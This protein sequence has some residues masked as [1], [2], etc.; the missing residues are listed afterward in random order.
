MR[1][2]LEADLGQAAR[3]LLAQGLIVAALHDAEQRAAGQRH[4]RRRACSARPNAASSFMARSISALLGRQPHAFVELHGD[5]GTE[6]NLHFNGALGRQLHHGAVEMRTERHALLR[7]FAQRG[8]RHHLKAAGIGEDRIR[9]AHE[10]VQ[11]AERRDALGGRAQ[12]QMIGIGQHD[13]DARG[14]DVVVMNA[15]DGPLE[16]PPA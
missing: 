6:Q 5:V 15:F 3:A 2:A 12:H 8:E 7:D 10:A 9:P 11:P 14:A 16:S 4:S 1:V 13:V